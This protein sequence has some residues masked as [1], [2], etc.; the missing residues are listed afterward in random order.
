MDVIFFQIAVAGSIILAYGIALL[1]KTSK[2]LL[3]AA[4][5]TAIWSVFTL[6]AVFTIPLI[7]I[8]LAVAGG[9]F[10]L[11]YKR[12]QTK[13]AFASQ[14]AEIQRLKDNVRGGL[15]GLSA[16]VQNDVEQR[17][18]NGNYD[19]VVGR[20]HEHQLDKALDSA[21]HRLI[22]LSG[23]VRASVVNRHRETHLE[24][25]LRRGVNVTIG[26]GW[27]G[28]E[29]SERSHSEREGE[30]RL[31][32]LKQ[33]AIKF[34][35]GQLEIVDFSNHAKLLLVDQEYA[36]C[37]S[38]NW[39]SNSGTRNTEIS[40]LTRDK[41]VIEALANSVREEINSEYTCTAETACW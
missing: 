15:S 33:R 12:E 26:Y 27:Q 11:C 3:P 21:H 35:G 10:Y 17:I 23:W 39:L 40:L 1:L 38:H 9:S 31:T 19:V 5:F 20:D 37:G 16:E 8:Q 36:V 7:L 28:H 13:Q 29:P 18:S 22:I 34:G 14:S 32:H 25:A 4:I 41:H 30:R 2:P 6:I 24:N